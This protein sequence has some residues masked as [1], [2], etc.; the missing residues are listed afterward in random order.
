MKLTNH[1]IVLFCVVLLL[2][3][4][5]SCKKF[6]EVTPTS[7]ASEGAF[8]KTKQDA[9]VATN[10]CYNQLYFIYND[11]WKFGE[12][13]ADNV[14]DNNLALSNFTFDASNGDVQNTWTNHYQ[15][16]ARC[17]TLFDNIGDIPMDAALKN[18]YQME[19]KFL[20]GLYYFN[21]VRL[22]GEVPIVTTETKTIKAEFPSRGSVNDVYN[23]IISDLTEAENLP[24]SYPSS[25][26]GRATRGAAKALLAKVYLTQKK[27]QLA[28]NKA[29]EVIALGN[30]DLM[31]DYANVF[32]VNNQNNIESVFEV[33]YAR[34]AQ[35]GTGGNL[36]NFF[37]SEFAP[38]GQGG[39]IV[40]GIPN[41]NTAGNMAPT[42]AFIATYEANDPRKDKS[43]KT[44]YTNPATNSPVFVNYTTKYLDAT[45]D[46]NNGSGNNFRLLRFADVLLIYAEALNE[47]SGSNPLAFNAINKVRARARGANPTSVLRDLTAL[48]QADFRQAIYKERRIELAF[49]FDRWFDLKRTGTLITTMRPLK[50][51]QGRNI[52]LPIPQRERQLNTKLT[53]NTGYEN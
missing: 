18:Q 8:Y 28:A 23:L 21:L 9:L 19:A 6:L 32:N 26:L 24:I 51:I 50:N 37:F 39:L 14:N 4:L 41:R 25:D 47:I 5:A 29:A 20:R 42:D 22:F 44:F 46:G 38:A 40:T 10:A 33:Q 48:N 16:I 36:T 43:L 2:S 52:L 49:E 7:V 31:P 35:T 17:N 27:W 15:A 12:V 45:A 13:M 1:N 3:S 34:V 11:L 53:Q 30:Y